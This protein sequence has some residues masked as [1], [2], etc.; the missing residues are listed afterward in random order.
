MARVSP[1]AV[2]Q[3]ATGDVGLF[4][5]LMA[6]FGKVFGE[7]DSYTGAQP[8]S[9][10]VEALLGGDQFI[11]LVALTDGGVGGGLAAYELKKFER[12]RSEIYIYDLAV[13][14]EHR[15][16]GI[17]T[18]LIEALKPIAAAR[19]AYV[20]IVQADR[21]DVAPITLYSKLGRREDIHHFDIKV[22]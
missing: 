20:L 16:Q 10:Y 3:L 7:M 15:P 8:R 5:E 2:H 22:D 13:D 11:G 6:L 18:A 21:G 14:A 4:R 9:A 19:G 1:F 12:E 17:A